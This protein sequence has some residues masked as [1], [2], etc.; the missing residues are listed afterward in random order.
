MPRSTLILAF[1]ASFGVFGFFAHGYVENTDTEVTLHAARAWALRGNP[2]LVRFQDVETLIPGEPHWWGEKTIALNISDPEFQRLH[3]FGSYGRTGPDGR[4]YV[5]FP[6]GHQALLVPCVL[7]GELLADAFPQAEANYLERAPTL[8]E[9]REFYWTRVLVSFVSPLFAAGSIVVL[10]LLAR[11]LGASPRQS[12]FVVAFATLATQFLPGTTETMSNVPGAFFLYATMLAIARYATR[13]GAAH[14]LLAGSA[15]GAGV[16]LRYPIALS[17]LPLFAWALFDANRRA[18]RVEIL[19]LALGGLPALVFLL[20]A[21]AWRFGSMLETGYSS[22]SSFGSEWFPIGVLGILF[23]PSKGVFWFSPPLWLAAW[24]LLLGPAAGAIRA[25]LAALL[26]G[27]MR[28]AA[29][30]FLDLARWHGAPVVVALASFALPVLS[31]ASLWYWG[32]GQCWGIRYLT[33]PLVLVLVAMFTRH[34]DALAARPVRTGAMFV[35][36]LVVSIGGLIAPYTGQQA[37]AYATIHARFG[38]F[39]FGGDDDRIFN[40]SPELSPIHSHWTYAW[41]SWSGRIETG[42]SEDT[43]EPLFGIALENPPPP[44]AGHDVRFRHLWWRSLPEYVQGFPGTV[45]ALVW[46]LATLVLGAACVRS[47][48]SKA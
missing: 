4:Q 43:T 24:L 34:R 32:S 21:N 11:E 39:E 45:V 18:R 29:R 36:G 44:M 17:M 9:F 2:G 6:I 40:W 47:V 14:L 48:W 35:L 25:G 46:A 19:W 1:L 7:L 30:A 33:G 13:G 15:A 38:P 27:R 42:K 12:L 3:G 10:L 20:W 5:W 16:L 22:E 31:V 28:G 8:P 23:A 26:R 41:L 37:L